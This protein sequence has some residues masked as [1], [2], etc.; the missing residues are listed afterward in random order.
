LGERLI[1][2]RAPLLLLFGVLTAFLGYHASFLRM[3]PG[4]NKSIPVNHPY[5]RIYTEY[6]NVFGG[7]NVL[8]VALERRSGDIFTPEFMRTL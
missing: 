4:F 7:A 3:D 8:I 1:R 6:S 5:M 2:R